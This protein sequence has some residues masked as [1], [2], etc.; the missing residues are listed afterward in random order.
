MS[1]AYPDAW[2]NKSLNRLLS[3]QVTLI[4][5]LDGKVGEE[6]EPVIPD[7]VCDFL[8]IRESQ[9]RYR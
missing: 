3:N 8:K 5:L 4:M 9:L 6:P 7:G 2:D 1:H